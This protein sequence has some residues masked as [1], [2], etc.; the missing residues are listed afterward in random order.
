MATVEQNEVEKLLC[1]LCGWKFTP[2]QGR[3]HGRKFTCTQCGSANRQLRRHLGEG[4]E[5]VC[6]FDQEDAQEFYRALQ[7]KKSPSGPLGWK[8]V[9]AT[10]LTCAVTRHITRAKSLL[11]GEYLPLSVWTSR[12]W[13]ADVVEKQEKEW[14]DDLGLWTYRVHIKALSWEE[15]HERMEETLLRHEREASKKRGDKAAADLDLPLQENKGKGEK[16]DKAEKDANKVALTAAK[17]LVRE[18][19]KRCALAARGIGVY[20]KPVSQLHKLSAKVDSCPEVDEAV[21]KA[22]HEVKTRLE[23]CVEKSRTVVNLAEGQKEKDIL[24]QVALPALPFDQADLKSLVKQ[25]AVVLRDTRNSFPKP[26]PKAK[27][28]GRTRSAETQEPAAGGE[29]A[30]V[31][32]RRTKKGGA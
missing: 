11:T 18:N 9:R 6:G 15:T 24:E 14:R 7:Q 10:L 16:G 22:F 5:Q 19:E 31:K 17:K 8:T 3:L 13:D 23:D 32:R 20:T 25:S 26:V 21:K 2:E 27:A 29:G 30:E 4:P 28:A 1:V 12:G